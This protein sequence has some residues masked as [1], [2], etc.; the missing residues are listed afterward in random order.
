MC[1]C[2]KVRLVV[3]VTRAPLKDGSHTAF[4][5]MQCQECGKFVGFPHENFMLAVE[6]GNEETLRG[7]IK[8]MLGQS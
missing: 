3:S 7:L 4:E 6:Q 8:H 1:Q 5:L 2:T